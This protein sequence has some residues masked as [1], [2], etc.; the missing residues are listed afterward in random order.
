M[1]HYGTDGGT[2][3][4]IQ[5]ALGV[6]VRKHVLNNYMQ[7]KHSNES[8][9]SSTGLLTESC[10]APNGNFMGPPTPPSPPRTPPVTE[11]SHSLLKPSNG[12]RPKGMMVPDR[13]PTTIELSG[14]CARQICPVLLR[15]WINSLKSH[16]VTVNITP[17]AHAGNDIGFIPSAQCAA[18]TCSLNTRT[19]R[20][21]QGHTPTHLCSVSCMPL[22]L[23]T[24]LCAS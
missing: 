5:Y 24:W 11:T 6:L 16:S 13:V 10:S 19:L 23:V 15:L 3:I 9:Y 7:F 21:G 1:A 4:G 18:S 20:Q 14:F 2:S 8:T 12:F 17:S 22:V